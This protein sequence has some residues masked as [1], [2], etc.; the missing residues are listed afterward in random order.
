MT[1][2]TSAKPAVN[3]DRNVGSNPTGPMNSNARMPDP[4]H[5]V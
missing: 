2:P 3:T 5:I 4:D 1:R